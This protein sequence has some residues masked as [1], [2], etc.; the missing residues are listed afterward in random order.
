MQDCSCCFVHISHGLS[1]VSIPLR[2]LALGKKA[3]KQGL[4]QPSMFPIEVK[5]QQ[6][7]IDQVRIIP[8]KGFYVVEVVYEQAVKQSA[9]NPAYYAGVDLGVNNLAALASNPVFSR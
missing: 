2:F 9:V 8:R 1:A 6:Q 3:L 5:T 7:N 4:I